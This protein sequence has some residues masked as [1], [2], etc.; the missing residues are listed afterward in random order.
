MMN[1]WIFIVCLLFASLGSSAQQKQLISG[2]MLG[3][4]AH[5]EQL[6]WLEV[7]PEVK[8][9]EIVYWPEEK[10]EKKYS[11]HYLGPLGRSYNPVKVV[12][13]GLSMDTRYHYDIFL[14]GTKAESGQ[15]QAFRTTRLWQW[16]EPAPDFSFLFG[17]CMYVND[18][19]FDRPGDPYGQGLGMV[20]TMGRT[21][22][23]FMIWGGDNVYLRE[24]DWSSLDGIYYRYSHDRRQKELATLLASRP[25]FAIPDDHDFGPN[26]SNRSWRLKEEV[27][28]VFKEYWGN[29]KMGTPE[30][31]GL[32][33]SFE[34]SDCAFFLLDNRSFRSPEFYHD[35]SGVKV[36]KTYL[37]E[38]QMQWLKDNLASSRAPFKF[39]VSGSQV[40][41]TEGRGECFCHYPAEW[42]ELLEFI[43]EYR[44]N[45]V[46]FLSGDRHYSEVLKFQQSGI[47]PI[48]EIT[49]SP[50]SSRPYYS[51]D[52]GDEAANPLRVK[53]T[54]SN[55]LN[56][57]KLSV[58]GERYR[59][60]LKVEDLDA[61]GKL[62]WEIEI[63][64]MEVKFIRK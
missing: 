17:S 1:K 31:P 13:T 60:V 54:L 29:Q 24:A 46:I 2:P 14:D 59:R 49:S 36:N 6:I 7:S 18:P 37:G 63:P 62:L 30:N 12:L 5:H 38:K 11:R 22:S 57:M 10:P 53:G 32:Y 41:N 64:E 3:Y 33:S 42:Q 47:Y 9:L 20:E 50:I 55:Q 34:W 19:P 27:S 21:P 58:S 56:F 25:N 43:R 8:D 40:L 23:D 16:R 39:I 35:S 45:G 61:E 28:R 51:I 26:N 44:I 4:T 15:E 48:Y 52:K